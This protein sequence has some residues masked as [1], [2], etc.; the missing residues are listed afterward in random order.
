[1]GFIAALVAVRNF[2]NDCPKENSVEAVLPD[3]NKK[4]CHFPT[5]SP[6]TCAQQKLTYALKSNIGKPT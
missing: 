4:N 1:M 6:F 2:I 5:F 3:E